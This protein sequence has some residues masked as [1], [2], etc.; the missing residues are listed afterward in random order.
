MVYFDQI[1]HTNACQHYLTTVMCNSLFDGRGFAGHHFSPTTGMQNGDEA[2]PNII[3]A[4][5]RLLVKML[6]TLSRTA[7][8]IL[9]K[10]CILIHFNIVGHW[11]AKR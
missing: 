6:I 7:P 11:Y 4:G 8:Y 10:F 1:L 9:I 5:Q 3:L 2:L